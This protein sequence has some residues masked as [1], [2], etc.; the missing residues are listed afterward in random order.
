MC[1]TAFLRPGTVQAYSHPITGLLDV[2]RYPTGEDPISRH[3]AA[4]FTAATYN[5][6][7]IP[8]V[9]RWE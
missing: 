1:P 6:R 2:G 8:D 4:A 3:I 7:S 5:A 9:R